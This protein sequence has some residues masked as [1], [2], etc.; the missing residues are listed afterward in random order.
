MFSKKKKEK[1]S[2]TTVNAQSVQTPQ[3]QSTAGS[4]AQVGNS[5]TQSVSTNQPLTTTEIVQSNT[6]A[7]NGIINTS[8]M[9]N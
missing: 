3:N 8:K 7:N 5:L 1:E 6:I 2:K 9:I 4:V